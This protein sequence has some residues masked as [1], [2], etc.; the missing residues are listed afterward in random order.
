MSEALNKV[1][2]LRGVNYLWKSKE[3]PEK[4]FKNS[5]DMGLIAQEVE[6]IVPEVVFELDDGYKAIDYGKLV[7]LL[8]E[9]IKE[10]QDLIE[11]QTNKISLMESNFDERLKEIEAMLKLTSQNK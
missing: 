6:L 1:L 10:Q 3:F 2:N 11:Q 4:Q 7:G 5:K 9:A 8:I